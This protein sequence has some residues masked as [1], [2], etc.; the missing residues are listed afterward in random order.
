MSRIFLS[1]SSNDNFEA[2]ALRDWL[3]SEGWEDVFLDLD[4]ERGIAA[5]ERWERALHAAANRCEAVIFLVSANWLASGWCLQ[6]YAL[7]RG[8]N[9][10]LFAA[11]IDPT[12]TID[13]LPA[14]LTG[15]WQIVNL[16]GGQD[17]R[18]LQAQLSGSHEERHVAYSQSGL[19]RL[20]RG[21]EKA[22]LD[23]RFFPW[24]PENEPGRAPYRG[25]KPQEAA[26][27]G[28]FFGRDAP[29]VEA[30]DKL[31]GLRAGAPPR[32]FAILGASGTGKSS[33]LRAGLL[34]RLKRDDSQFI[35]LTVVRPERAAL[36]GETG[37][38][39]AL[40]ALLPKRSRAELRAVLQA[41]AAAIR[42]LLAQLAEA[43]AAQ[44]GPADETERPPAFVVAI[45][46]AEELF[47]AE[48]REESAALLALL[49]DLAASDD[50]AVIVIFA[51]RS[52][53][54][55]A[56]QNAKA[57]EGLR[58]EAL[59][60]LP[61]PRGAYV[62]VIEGPAQR[63]EGSGRKLKIDPALTQ[64]LLA[65]IEAGAGDA[66][67]LL[68][69]TLEQ[70]YLDYRQTEALRLADYERMGGLRGAID[71]AVERALARGDSDPRI[72]RDREARFALLRR[73]LIP[74]LAGVDPDSKTPRRNIA[75]YSDI[76]SEAVPLLDLLVEERLLSA[77]MR[78]RR[79]LITG[80]ETREP[81]IEPTHE[82]LLRQW[83]LLD[84][85]LKEDF[86]L[87]TTL[88]G[89]KRAGG[90][91]DANA[92]GESWLSHQGQ[93]LA[94]AQALEARRDLAVRLDATDHAYLVGCR[95]REEKARVDAE[96]RRREREKDQ[97]RKLDDARKITWRATVAIWVGV[98]AAVIGLFGLLTIGGS[99]CR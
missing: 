43:A 3:A 47:R 62:N 57:L 8:L 73:G 97:K 84:S 86:A 20:K 74:W 25:L 98:V 36:S 14:E 69:F 4:P 49:A 17:H 72:P 58:Q 29:I 59:P 88:E 48:A 66:L 19:T 90:E 78:V 18:L 92:R 35:P 42:R 39:N 75:L 60:L 22:G 64:R 6:E 5:G 71:A 80:E 65:D 13:S 34:P 99:Y 26:D 52:D 15:V 11:L 45:D 85:W 38:I 89:V 46:Q 82:A 10:K 23:P 32:I 63:M 21:L 40:T 79:D 9:K 37:L 16:V 76:P 96:R 27:A 70:L 2:V 61:M 68:A 83:G 81:T 41:G 31:R 12:K 44:R 94:E 24:P 55:D 95:A 54:Y 51:I 56:L 67:P 53:S 30:I 50:P 1:H 28:I 93:R 91:W 33:F 7:A 87:L 77:D